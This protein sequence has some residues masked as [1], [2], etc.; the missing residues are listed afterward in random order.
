MNPE[1]IPVVLYKDPGCF[2]EFEAMEGNTG[3]KMRGQFV[4]DP[5]H[6]VF[7][8]AEFPLHEI[9]IHVQVLMVDLLYDMLLHD[10]TQFLHV[11]DETG[12]RIGVSL[13]R[14]IKFKI[15]PVPVLIGAFAEDL[16]I[17]LRRPVG[18]VELMSGVKM[19]DAGDIN[20]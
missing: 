16:V 14:N 18:I 9:H 11:E 1:L 4:P 7:D 19:F 17:L 5:D 12:L 6:Q 2:V 10:H 15:M 3:G 8:G 20:H 13:D